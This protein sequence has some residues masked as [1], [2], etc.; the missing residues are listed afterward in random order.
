M[1]DK[2]EGTVKWFNE[3]KGF[4]FIAQ[5]NGGQD[6]FAHYSA[7]QGSGFKT[8]AEGQ[9]VSFILGEGKKVHKL[10]KSKHYNLFA[11]WAH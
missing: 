9:K 2:V 10:S 3:A 11:V 1:S 6:V 5:D 7:I 8:L 4:G